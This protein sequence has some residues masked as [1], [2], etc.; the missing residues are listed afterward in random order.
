MELRIIKNLELRIK[1]QTAHFTLLLLDLSLSLN[2]NLGFCLFQ[3]LT[4]TL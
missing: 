3:Y 1:N 4:L 2:L